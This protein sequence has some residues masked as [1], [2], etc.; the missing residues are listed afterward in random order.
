M[1]KPNEKKT[2]RPIERPTGGENSFAERVFAFVDYQ[3]AVS[4]GAMDKNCKCYTNALYSLSDALV[5][6]VLKKI[7]NSSGNETIRKMRAQRDKSILDNIQ[8]ASNNA[9][10]KGYNKDG[11]PIEIIKDSEL[12]RSIKTMISEGVSSRFDLVQSTALAILETV[13]SLTP[14]EIMRDELWRP[15][16]TENESG[17]TENE[18]GEIAVNFLTKQIVE[19][20]LNRRIYITDFLT[21]S[22]KTQNDQIKTVTFETTRLQSYCKS[23]RAYILD[24]NRPEENPQKFCYIDHTIETEEGETVSVYERFIPSVMFDFRGAET[25]PSIIEIDPDKR[26]PRLPLVKSPE[27]LSALEIIP[28]SGELAILPLN[29]RAYIS[30]E[31]LVSKLKLTETQQKIIAYRLKS[32]GSYGTKA[33]ATA[34][35]LSLNTVKSGLREI[36]NKLIKSGLVSDK[37][38]TLIDR[39]ETYSFND[40]KSKYIESGIFPEPPRDGVKRPIPDIKINALNVCSRP[41]PE[42]P[43]S[44][45]ARQLGV[46]AIDQTR[47]HYSRPTEE[48]IL[49]FKTEL[50]YKPIDVSM[51]C[52][53]SN[54]TARS[55]TKNKP[56]I[57]RADMSSY[58]R[59]SLQRDEKN[60]ESKKDQTERPKNKVCKLVS[61]PDPETRVKKPWI[62]T[63]YEKEIIRAYLPPRKNQR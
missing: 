56:S 53:I 48:H 14:E 31:T 20:R 34:T 10:E 40:I 44:V 11:E 30:F 13:S 58:V 23:I 39:L 33:I 41:R 54:P 29:P 60:N 18:S 59:E 37:R 50:E 12:D 63:A 8:Y 7:Y 27:E 4:S 46:Y 43:R 47:D 19:T 32:S 22:D 2:Y 5:S 9:R 38:L 3:R 21:Q 26:P 55:E 16:E 17:E 45:N 15:D 1:K 62:K 6:C 24:E 25:R 57:Y 51:I 52:D 61:I 28:T 49:E 42:L 36:K 35:G